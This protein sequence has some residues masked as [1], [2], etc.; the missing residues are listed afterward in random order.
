MEQQTHNKVDIIPSFVIPVMCHV[1]LKEC[2][3]NTEKVVEESA[4][5]EVKK[6]MASLN[7]DF[8]MKGFDG[9]GTDSDTNEDDEAM[10]GEDHQ[11]MPDNVESQNTNL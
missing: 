4:V 6:M 5:D 7:F 9:K 8:L 11:A 1:G 10:P 3:K 2:S